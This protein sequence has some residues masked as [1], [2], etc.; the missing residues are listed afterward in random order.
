[1]EHFTITALT[2]LLLGA[3]PGCGPSESLPERSQAQASANKTSPAK[4]DCRMR[5]SYVIDVTNM[6][7]VAGFA[8]HIF[9]GSVE[10]ELPP[11]V[12]SPSH[13]DFTVSSQASLKGAPS[14]PL[15][16]RQDGNRQCPLKGD[17]ILEV[18]KSYV[19]AVTEDGVNGRKPLVRAYPLTSSEIKAATGGDP[20]RYSGNLSAMADAIANQTP[21]RGSGR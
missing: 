15:D 8:D 1:M 17:S 13:T 6:R 12:D 3:V 21:W 4:P 10:R 9:A 19:F 16:I 11:D 5:A 2:L 20:A 18:G 7:A 14:G